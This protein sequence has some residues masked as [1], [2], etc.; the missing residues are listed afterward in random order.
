MRQYIPY[1]I[2]VVLLFLLGY[3]YYLNQNKDKTIAISNQN[4]LA[5]TDSL[6]ISETKN[7]ELIADKAV[8]ISTNGDL[9]DLNSVLSD[10]IK[11][12]NGKVIRLTN[13]VFELR[14]R[15]PII[16]HDTLHVFNNDSLLVKWQKDVHFDKYNYR[17][18]AGQTSISK[19]NDVIFNQSRTILTK[20][21]IGVSLTTGLREV[22][23]KIMI[24]VTSSYP[25]FS[26]TKLD[27]A[28]IDPKKNPIYKEFVQK[29]KPWGIGVQVG[30]G[31]TKDGLS[32]YIGGG[33]SYNFIRF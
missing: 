24:F 13:T 12:I 28:E 17:F 6:N 1:I 25:G 19:K 29:K 32:P 7:G 31:G 21:V 5:L 20:D 11:E 22:D 33:I 15:G 30:Y 8:L 9:K 16:L 10:Q 3:G 27:G 23:D 4:I 26:V 2:I 14:S 18:I